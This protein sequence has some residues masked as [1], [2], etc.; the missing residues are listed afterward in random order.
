MAETHVPEPLDWPIRIPENMGVHF[1][2]LSPRIEMAMGLPMIGMRVSKLREFPAM[3]L[4]NTDVHRI[5][6][7]MVSWMSWM[8]VRIRLA[9]QAKS[10]RS[11]AALAIR[12]GMALSMLWT[13]A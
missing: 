1:R 7:G 6:M 12:M 4:G 3:T 13:R 2:I 9:N 11:M 5:G 10:R 8:R